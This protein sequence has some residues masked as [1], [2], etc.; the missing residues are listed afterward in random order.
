MRKIVAVALL[1][2]IALGAS[3]CHPGYAGYQDRGA[4][5]II[6]TCATE[7]LTRCGG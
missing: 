6:P 2:V 5:K 7:Q 1:S 4:H 3:A